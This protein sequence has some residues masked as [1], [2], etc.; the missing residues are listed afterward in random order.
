[1]QSG[2]SSNNLIPDVS[3]IQRNATPLPAERIDN[4][5]RIGVE[6]QNPDEGAVSSS[7]FAGG[8]RASSVGAYLSIN[9]NQIKALQA[10][11]D[12]KRSTTPVHES[13]DGLDNSAIAEEQPET[14]FDEVAHLPYQTT[15]TGRHIHFSANSPAMTPATLVPLES[16]FPRSTATS[17]MELNPI[18]SARASLA[19]IS[20]MEMEDSAD[21]PTTPGK[22]ASLRGG[23]IIA[24]TATAQLM[25]LI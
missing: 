1:M 24:V 10:E 2:Q 12:M 19:E 16:P 9:R 8:R 7:V 17:I 3:L 5:I 13:K 20:R 4:G 21:D 25:D 14:P 11:D 18:P 6:A 23:T 15:G 22:I